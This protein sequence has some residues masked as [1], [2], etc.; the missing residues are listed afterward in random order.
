MCVHMKI[1]NN[2]CAIAYRKGGKGCR[3]ETCGTE[4]AY[5]RRVH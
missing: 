2:V 5:P 1:Q 4:T 3:P